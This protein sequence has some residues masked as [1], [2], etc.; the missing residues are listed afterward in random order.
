MLLSFLGH[1]WLAYPGHSDYCNGSYVKKIVFVIIR[2]AGE[3]E[4]HEKWELGFI[5]KLNQIKGGDYRNI[6]ILSLQKNLEKM[7]GSVSFLIY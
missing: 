1:R 5:Q 4:Q 3:E 6:F 2:D 7:Q